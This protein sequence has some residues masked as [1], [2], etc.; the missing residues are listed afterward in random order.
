MPFIK[1]KLQARQG[2]GRPTG[3]TNETTKQVKQI[4]LDIINDNLDQIRLDIMQLEPRDRCAVIIQLAKLILPKV[5][6]LETSDKIGL[7]LNQC[8]SNDSLY[9][10]IDKI[11]RFLLF[12]LE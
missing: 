10:Y 1:G 7:F 5:K 3:S 9:A 4:M 12:L 11:P 6:P 8:A 2:S